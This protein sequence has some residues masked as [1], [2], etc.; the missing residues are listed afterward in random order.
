MITAILLVV[1]VFY[2]TL[3]YAR[4][5]TWK[6]ELTLWDDTVHKSPNK[7]RPYNGRGLA[8]ALSDRYDQ[9]ISDFNKAIA[10]DPNF[11]KAYNNR[12]VVYFYHKEYNK[13]WADVHR[14]EKL[15]YVVNPKFLEALKKASGRE[16]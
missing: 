1:T 10:L 13:A 15:G 9:A 14:A 5:I 7:A 3:T 8:Y 2:G 4:N 11:D 16:E 6:Y 12:G